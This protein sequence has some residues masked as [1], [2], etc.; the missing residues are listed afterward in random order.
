MVWIIRWIGGGISRTTSTGLVTGLFFIIFGSL[1]WELV[2]DLITKSPDWLL[3][4]WIRLGAVIIGLAII[5]A[6]LKFNVWS[7][8]QKVVDELAEML[9]DAI[10]DLLNRAVANDHEL[11]KFEADFNAWCKKVVAK[12]EDSPAY[13]SKADKLHFERL[14]QVP[15]HVWGQAYK[16]MPNDGRHNHI[17]CMLSVKFDRLRDVIN[18]AQQRPR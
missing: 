11:G 3:S 9:S 16:A 8:K 13:F 14:G 5:G 18:W 10:H 1:P 6:S 17:L 7:R 2:A 4:G 12:I 15:V